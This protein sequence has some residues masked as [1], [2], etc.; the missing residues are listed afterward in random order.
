MIQK[1]ICMLGG[2]AVGKTS[3]VQRF[4]K[5]IFSEKYLTTVGVKIDKKVV[6][7]GGREVSLILWDLHGEDDFQQVQMSYMRGG[8]GL[9]SGCGWHSSRKSRYRRH[10]AAKN[11]GGRGTGPFYFPAQ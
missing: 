1:K 9:P 5:G 4:V 7:V 6:Q 3:L 2:Y 11:R 10:P 8:F